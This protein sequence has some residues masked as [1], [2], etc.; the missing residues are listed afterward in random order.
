MKTYSLQEIFD[1]FGYDL[2]KEIVK[3]DKPGKYRLIKMVYYWNTINNG[4][5]MSSHCK[6]VRDNEYYV[7]ADLNGAYL[8]YKVWVKF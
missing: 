6:D 8:P 3:T 4:G 1:K 7:V 5:C 2:D